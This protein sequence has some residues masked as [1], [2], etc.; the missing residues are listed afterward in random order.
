MAD[1]RFHFALAVWISYAAW[2]TDGAIVLEQI[3]IQ[4][5]ERRI[6]DIRREHAFSEV[7][8][9]HDASGPAQPPAMRRR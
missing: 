1:A 9:N 2:Q 3:T 4:R 6:V 7:I 5:I 8:E